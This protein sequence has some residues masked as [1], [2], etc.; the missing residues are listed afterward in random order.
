[1]PEPLSIGQ[2]KAARLNALRNSNE[3]LNEAS[4]LF[5]HH[6]WARVAF[7]AQA[8]AEEIGKYIMVTSALVEVIANPDAFN[9]KKFW[10]RYLSH[11]RKSQ[12]MIVFEDMLLAET[13][14]L[15]T[16]LKDMQKIVSDLEMARQVSPYSGRMGQD[17]Y[18]PSELFTEK[19]ANNA[20]TWA[21]GRTRLIN[22]LENNLLSKLER[23]SI[24]TLR[25]RLLAFRD[26]FGDPFK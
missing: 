6:C 4:I 22:E 19:M 1:M 10:R 21:G 20:L 12:E 18:C 24:E 14:V 25:E 17:F 16:Y 15:P 5:D 8:V 26:K 13:D 9:W 2:L 23:M 7:F 3:L 11:T